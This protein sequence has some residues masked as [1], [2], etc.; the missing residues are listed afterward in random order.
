MTASSIK[1]RAN[2]RKDEIKEKATAF[3]NQFV[4]IVHDALLE[5]ADNI[6]LDYDT[7]WFMVQL[8]HIDDSVSVCTAIREFVIANRE[9]YFLLFDNEVIPGIEDQPSSV[10]QLYKH[11][12]LNKLKNMLNEEGFCNLET[13]LPLEFGEERPAEEAYTWYALEL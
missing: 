3:A 4:E 7:R 5:T 13:E 1:E 9:H 11:Y 12:V 6:A 8:D 2:H 10:K